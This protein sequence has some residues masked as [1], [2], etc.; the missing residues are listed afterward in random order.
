MDENVLIDKDLVRVIDL[1]NQVKRLNKMI[2][3]HVNESKD[4]FMINQYSDRK[5]RFL[6]ELKEIL[7]G[8][9]IDVLIKGKAA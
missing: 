2:D 1:L 5:E 9:E 3:L 8:F 7:S 6:K 4:S